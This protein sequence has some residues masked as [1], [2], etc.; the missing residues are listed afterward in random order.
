MSLPGL[1]AAMVVSIGLIGLIACGTDQDRVTSGGQ[2]QSGERIPLTS[3]E[4][5]K[6]VRERTGWGKAIEGEHLPTP[7]PSP[8]ILP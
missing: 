2:S 6:I 5:I 1:S 4:A 8:A 7:T 3:V